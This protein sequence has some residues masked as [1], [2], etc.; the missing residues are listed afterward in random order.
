[1]Y[2]YGARMYMPE[3]GRWGV[4][5]PLAEKM[6]RYSPYNY[7][8]NNPIRFID[9]DGMEPTQGGD[10]LDAYIQRR[11]GVNAFGPQRPKLT[12]NDWQ[13]KFEQWN[14]RNEMVAWNKLSS[15]EK[16][17]R[18][19]MTAGIQLLNEAFKEDVQAMAGLFEIQ[20]YLGG[21][22]MATGNVSSFF[23]TWETTTDGNFVGS[24]ATRLGR[25]VEAVDQP[26]SFSGG[27]GDV[28]IVTKA[29]NIEVKSGNKMKLTQSLKNSEYAKSKG[30]GYILY[31]PKATEK[32]I[33]D[34]S[35]K[36]IK[37]IKSENVL[38]KT[39]K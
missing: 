26:F 6:T 10:D 39:I 1:M 4:V 12:K 22:G 25:A 36:G 35:K 30:K 7:A 11:G 15:S 23:R 38:L 37:V 33:F 19:R 32:Q 20:S 9:P 24:L 28:D 3:L 5:D 18:A 2:D 31:M 14:Y 21:S 8:F 34:A 27:A 16:N 17:Q 13:N 29:Y